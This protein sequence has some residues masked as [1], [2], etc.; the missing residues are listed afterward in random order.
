MTK[1]AGAGSGS[2]SHRHGSGSGSRFFLSVAD[3]MHTKQKL[4][5]KFFCLLLF[6]GTFSLCFKDKKVKKKSQNSINQGFFT[7][8]LLVGG[9]IWIRTNIDGKDFRKNRNYWGKM[10]SKIH[11]C[12][13]GSSAAVLRIG[14]RDPLP[15]WPRDTGRFFPDP[16]PNPK[17]YF[18][19]LSDNFLG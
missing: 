17:P 18:W 13:L 12:F 2:M 14:I 9:R 7:F 1:M 6:E 10:F 8:C 15:F 3:K 16:G 5:F 19:E 11:S 4:F